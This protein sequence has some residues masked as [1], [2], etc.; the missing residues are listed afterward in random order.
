MRI[1][2]V[3]SYTEGGF[4]MA[5][6]LVKPTLK[7]NDEQVKPRSRVLMYDSE[8]DQLKNPLLIMHIVSI[9]NKNPLIHIC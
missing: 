4:Y 3:N 9:S 2:Y 1:R 8:T 5:I 6:T 7:S